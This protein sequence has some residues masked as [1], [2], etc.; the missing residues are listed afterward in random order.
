MGKRFYLSLLVIVAISLFVLYAA[1]RSMNAM[2]SYWQKQIIWYLLGFLVMLV[3]SRVN[4][5]FL[6]SYWWLLYLLALAMLV[7]VLVAGVRIRGSKSWVVFG[8][9]RFQP[10]ELAK[11]FFIVALARVVSSFRRD[12]VG[13]FSFYAIIGLLSAVPLLLVALEPDFGTA[14]VF[15]AVTLGIVYASGIPSF[16]TFVIVSATL[17]G[18]LI[19]SFLLWGEM[20]GGGGFVEFVKF[21]SRNASWLAFAFFFLSGI[22]FVLQKMYGFLKKYVFERIEGLLFSSGLGFAISYVLQRVLKDY[23]KAR[24][25]AFFD[26]SVDPLGVGYNVIQSTTAIGSGGILGRGFLK[27]PLTSL[28]FL[29]EP[30]TDFAFSV[31]GENFGLLG[32]AVF[33]VAYAYL[34]YSML[35][36]AQNSSDALGRYIVV[37]VFSMFLYHFLVNS[38]M[39][40]GIAPSIGIPLLLLGYGGSSVLSSFVGIGLVLSVWR[41][42]RMKSEKVYQV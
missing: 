10:S 34:L 24:I 11:I 31:L 16:H 30:A 2:S 35:R 18:V 23:Q 22:V 41:F 20:A 26:P 37:G 8:G 40:L 12:M 1:S 33:M 7:V 14:T 17:L 5:R 38:A 32:L 36:V 6:A 15:L 9:L 3:V 19:P 27:G 13:S 42:T 25:M 21:L 28:G 39:C 4:Y 29:P